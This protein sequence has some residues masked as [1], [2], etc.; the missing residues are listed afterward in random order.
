MEKNL[1]EF[2]VVA[3]MAIIIFF[4]CLY[5]ILNDYCYTFYLQVYS[6]RCNDLSRNLM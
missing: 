4:L 1:L 5:V 6:I 3:V 2:F